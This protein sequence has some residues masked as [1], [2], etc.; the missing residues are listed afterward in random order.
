VAAGSPFSTAWNGR[1][2]LNDSGAVVACSYPLIGDVTLPSEDNIKAIANN[3][4]FQNAVAMTSITFPDS[5]KTLGS[6]AFDG[7]TALTTVTMPGVTTISSSAFNG[8]TALTTVTMPKVTSIGTSAFSGCTAL[9][10]IMPLSEVTSIGVNAFR[11]TALTTVDIGSGITSI[12][13]YAFNGC[14]ALTSV[15]I[16]AETPPTVIASSFP[17]TTNSTL[18]FYVPSDK[19]DTYKGTSSVWNSATYVD[20]IFPIPTT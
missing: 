13:T 14:T 20:K 2:L 9:V 3:G 10:S 15:T 1:I 4:I 7:C 18:K 8:C 16:R 19:V 6:N 5:V 11:S 17:V 12:Q